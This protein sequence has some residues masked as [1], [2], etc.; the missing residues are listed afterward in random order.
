MPNDDLFWCSRRSGMKEVFL[1]PFLAGACGRQS[2]VAR[3][4]RAAPR[5]A[6]AAGGKYP[7][8]TKDSVKVLCALGSALERGYYSVRNGEVDGRQGAGHWLETVW[9]CAGVTDFASL[10]CQKPPKKEPRQQ[11]LQ[12]TL[13][14]TAQLRR[15]WAGVGC[16][17]TKFSAAFFASLVWPIAPAHRSLRHPPTRLTEPYFCTTLM[18]QRASLATKT[19][20]TRQLF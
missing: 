11:P 9:T 20:G 10:S 1:L 5:W 14:G 18:S 16:F 4:E 8:R 15:R 3:Q 12:D 19:T 7:K 6:Q 13:Q 2:T 17:S